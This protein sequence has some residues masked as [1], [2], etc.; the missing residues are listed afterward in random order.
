MRVCAA[1]VALFGACLTAS[2]ALAQ[3]CPASLQAAQRLILVTVPNLTSSNGSLRLFAR[4]QADASWRQ[5][6]SAQ[7]VNVGKRGIAWGRAFHDL[8]GD[9]EPVKIEG[10]KK[11]PAGIYPIGRPFGFGPSRLANYLQIDSDSVCVEDPSSRAY[12]T[13]T[14]KKAVGLSVSKETMGASPLY[15]RGLATNYPTDA[16]HKAGS[17]IFLHVWRAPNSGTSGCVTMPEERVAALQQFANGHQTVLALL[18]ESALPRLADCLPAAT[19]AQSEG[20]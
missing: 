5:V 2:G 8:A 16:A 13:I 6:G 18:P 1:F 4:T 10:D 20:R 17:C 7:P 15:R 3:S 9:D 11:S 19:T 14:S 12:N